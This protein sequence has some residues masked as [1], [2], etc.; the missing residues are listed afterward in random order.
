METVRVDRMAGGSLLRIL[1]AREKGNVLTSSLLRSL[2]A[3]LVDVDRHT[4]LVVLEGAG[5]NF[6][7]GA[8]VEEHRR[9]DVAA[10]LESFHRFIGHLIDCPVPTAALVRGK[11]LGGAFELALACNFVFAARDAAFACPEI[12]LGVF[13]PVLAALGPMRLGAAWTDRLALTGGALDA[14]T[15]L[16]LG[17]VTDCISE[18]EDVVRWFDKTLAPLSAHALRVAAQAVRRGAGSRTDAIADLEKLYLSRTVTSFDGN[19]GIEAF[20]A[21]RPPQWRDA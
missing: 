15:A 9:Q 10:M 6:S 18:I 20:L 16:G 13:P 17:F 5:K 1:F 21:K 7:F 2:D 19:E 14:Q 4:K 3:A 11:C 12:S 8:S